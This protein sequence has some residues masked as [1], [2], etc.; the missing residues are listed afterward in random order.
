LGDDRVC[1]YSGDDKKQYK[2]KL[3]ITNWEGFVEGCIDGEVFGYHSII[4]FKNYK[5]IAQQI[6]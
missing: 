2:A 5:E 6:D 4:P 1:H 3:I